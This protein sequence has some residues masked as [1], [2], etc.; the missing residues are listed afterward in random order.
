MVRMPE[1]DGFPFPDQHDE[2][3]QASLDCGAACIPDF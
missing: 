3:H 2:T 1:M